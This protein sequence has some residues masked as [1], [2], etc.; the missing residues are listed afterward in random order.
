MPGRSGPLGRTTWAGMNCASRED[1]AR[2]EVAELVSYHEQSRREGRDV[3]CE[4]IAEV[5]LGNKRSLRRDDRTVD[6]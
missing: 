4:D 5:V 6:H 1:I 3:G 2:I